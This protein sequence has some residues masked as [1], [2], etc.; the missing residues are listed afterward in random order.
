MACSDGKNECNTNAGGTSA[1]A[2]I[3]EMQA[4]A[5]AG[6]ATAVPA[7]WTKC[8]AIFYVITENEFNYPIKGEAPYIEKRYLAWLVP[9]VGREWFA[10]AQSL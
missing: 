3:V 10:S 1:S 8:Y 2:V 7:T 6:V 5:A 4:A 9:P